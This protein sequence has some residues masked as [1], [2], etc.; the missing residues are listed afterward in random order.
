MKEVVWKWEYGVYVPFCPYC[1]EP[2]YEQDSCTFCGEPYQWVEGEFKP[3]KVTR[4][5]YTVVQATNRHIHIY[6][7]GKMVLHSHGN[8][9]L[10]E[11]ELLKEI[12][13]YENL[14]SAGAFDKC[15]NDSNEGTVL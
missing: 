2:A 12:D 10:T 13:F 7:N 5:E 8:K 6:K 11:E 3:T 1:G 9:K 15:F 14:I 4:G